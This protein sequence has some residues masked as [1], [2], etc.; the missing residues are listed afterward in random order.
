MKLVILA[1][2]RGSRLGHETDLVPKPMV[3]IGTF[4]IIWHI[5]KYY[6]GYGITEFIICLGY[7]GNIIKDYFINYR[8]YTNDFRINLKRKKINFFNSAC[9][10]WDV[11]LL[12]TGINT[13]TGG[14]LKKIEK[15]ID[16]NTFLMTYGDGLS[17][18]DIKALIRTHRKFKK[19]ATV[20]SVIPPGRFGIL[21]SKNNLVN[22]FSEHSTENKPN[23]NGGFF[24]LNKDIFRYLKNDQ[25]IFEQTVMPKL[26]KNK[27][28]CTYMHRGFWHPMDTP[29][30]KE[31]L[32]KLWDSKKAPWQNWK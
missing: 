11:T 20:T 29:R 3:K 12:D 9:E 24:V 25:T 27:E 32:E 13:E 22:K 16:N 31:S 30:D 19:T 23:V 8:E 14:R 15:Y 2:G 7:K 6:Y 10:N 21:S 1:G 18:I 17:N 28:L 4:P 26:I 5:M